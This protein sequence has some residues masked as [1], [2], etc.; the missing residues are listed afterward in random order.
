M[1]ALEKGGQFP[2]FF[3]LDRWN[4]NPLEAPPATVQDVTP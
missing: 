3:T 4:R 1:Q 2:R